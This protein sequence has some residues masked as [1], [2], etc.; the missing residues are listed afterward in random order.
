M[1]LEEFHRDFFQDVIT[2][3][4]ADGNY[5]EDEFFDQFCEHLIDAGELETADRALHHRTGI[6]VDGYG[7]DPVS[8]QGVL[9]LIISDFSQSVEI[10]KFNASD[11]DILFKRLSTFLEKALN[12]KYRNALEETDPAF[13]LA[14]LIAT[15]WPTISKVRLFLIS[16]RV[17]SA[18]VDGREA[19]EL[20]GKPITYSVWDAERLR[21]FAT[22]GAARKRLK[23]I[24]SA[25]SAARWRSFRPT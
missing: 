24:W 15:R 21:K 20:Q 4:E 8:S 12:S 18:R 2:M 6:R 22:S 7:G 16:N 13:G 14:D 10:Q 17:L 9:S 5:A 3:A 19:G 1:E 23:S 11:M 25:I